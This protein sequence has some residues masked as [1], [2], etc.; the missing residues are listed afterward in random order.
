MQNSLPR[1]DSITTEWLTFVLRQT[2]VLP[3]GIVQAVEQENTESRNSATCRLLMRYS[4]DAAP[5][6]PGRLVL[7]RNLPAEWAVEAGADEVRFYALVNSLPDYPHNIT[8]ACY[9]AAYDHDAGE[10]FLLLQDLSATHQPPVT[11]D[12]QIS[13]VYAVPS[14]SS[15]IWAVV[16][17]LAQVH[18]YWWEHPLLDTGVFPLGYWSRSSDR[19]RLYLEKRAATWNRL[20]AAESSWFPVDLKALYDQLLARLPELWERY[21]EPRFR[22]R[23]HLTLIHGDAYFCNFLYPRPGVDGPTYLLDWQSPSFDIGAYDLV[24]LCATFWTSEHRHEDHR[25]ERMLRRYLQTL[26]D[27]GV[28]RYAWDDLV[29]DY[30]LGLIFWVLMPVQDAADGSDRDYWWPK[31]QCLATAFRERGCVALLG[32]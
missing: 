30:Q 11:R 10:S 29:T 27:R 23:R 3:A 19:F 1:P 8:V 25:E 14:D 17:T 28:R 2:G 6:A 7:K 32:I 24:I 4:P 18:A 16:D 21:L 26:Q 22:A 15:S 9:A 20:V 13:I 12:Q 31:M 5:G